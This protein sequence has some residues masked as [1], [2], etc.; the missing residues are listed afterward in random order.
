MLVPVHFR[1]PKLRHMSHVFQDVFLQAILKQKFI[2]VLAAFGVVDAG[3]SSWRLRLSFRI[4]E[5]D[6]FLQV[7]MRDSINLCQK[8]RIGCNQDVTFGTCSN[9]SFSKER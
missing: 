7:G 5:G 8:S 1:V 9:V 4:C 3:I 2:V 6:R